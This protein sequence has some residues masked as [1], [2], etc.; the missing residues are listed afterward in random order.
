MKTNYFTIEEENSILNGQNNELLLDKLV[1]PYLRRYPILMYFNVETINNDALNY[2]IYRLNK[3]NTYKTSA[4]DKFYDFC[5]KKLRI[6]AK[7][8]L[9]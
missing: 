3:F 7:N 8:L 6:Y 9:K 5:T 2:L 4:K 1:S